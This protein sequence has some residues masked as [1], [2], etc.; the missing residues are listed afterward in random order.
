MTKKIFIVD[1]SQTMVMSIKS[2]LEMGGFDV[3]SASDGA[4]A[5]EHLEKGHRP[6]LIITDLNMPRMTG[7]EL[8]RHVRAIP[9]FRFT[10][11]LTLTTESQTARREEGKRAGA[12]GWMVKP[13]AANDLL[14][15]VKRVIPAA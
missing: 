12:T 1:D 13:V 2:T 15:V 4:E 3:S 8:I 14:Q 11:I 9:H 7:I 6:D 10:P 5:L